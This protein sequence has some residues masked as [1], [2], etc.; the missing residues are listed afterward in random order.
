MHRVATTS[1]GEIAFDFGIL[2]R[3]SKNNNVV[4]LMCLVVKSVTA[5][6][7]FPFWSNERFNEI[8]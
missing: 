1:D 7:W 8:I 6:N 3:S 5:Y 4:H 2:K